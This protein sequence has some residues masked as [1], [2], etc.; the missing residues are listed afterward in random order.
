VIPKEGVTVWFDM[1]AIPVD[2][3]H[4]ENAHASLDYIM[5]PKLIAAISNLV[6][7]ANGN[8]ASLPYVAE[9]LLNDPSIFRRARSSRDSSTKNPGRLRWIEKWRV[10]GL[11]S[12]RGS[13]ARG[14][15]TGTL[16]QATMRCAGTANRPSDDRVPVVGLLR[17]IDDRRPRAQLAGAARVATQGFGRSRRLTATHD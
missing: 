7:E 2:T 16:E 3:P 12:R 1:I 8:A 6:G 11:G 14:R 4:P 9:S 5:E 10:P 17:R 15:K 13:S